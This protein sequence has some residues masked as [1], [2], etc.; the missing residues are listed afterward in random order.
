MTS[1]R[2]RRLFASDVYGVLMKKVAFFIWT[3]GFTGLVPLASGTA[4]SIVGLGLLMLVRTSRNDW[5]ELL[6]LLIVVTAGIWSANLAERHY[7]REDPGEV[8]VDEVAGM[9]LTLLWLPGG[10][11]ALLIGFL[12]FRFFDIVKPF[13]ARMAEQLP[14]GWGVMTDDLVAGLYGYAL[15]RTVLWLLPVVGM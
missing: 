13:P 1:S 12:A 14:G 6:V 4:G 7:G 8:V 15:V 2:I 10:W 5:M 9:M 11:G 3:A